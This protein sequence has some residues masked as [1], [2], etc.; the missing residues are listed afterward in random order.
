MLSPVLYR[1][2]ERL[3]NRYPDAEIQELPSGAALI[4]VSSF[5]L[6]EGWTAPRTT[7]WFI[8][9]TGYPGPCPDSFGVEPTLRLKNGPHPPQASNANQ[10]IPETSISALWF[11]W[12]IT[13]A[14][15][16][17]NSNRDD[18]LT[19]AGIIYNRFC[20]LQ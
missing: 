5:E 3:K 16:N 8:A 6:P 7:V 4:K 15:R 11:S 2:F 19:Y 9:P 13:E 18:L 12:H 14:Q 1:Q 10:V 17:W 20:K